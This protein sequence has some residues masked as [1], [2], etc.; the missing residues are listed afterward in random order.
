MGTT[1]GVY[2]FGGACRAAAAAACSTFALLCIAFLLVACG[3]SRATDDANAH[4][5]DAP[6]LPYHLELPVRPAALP[7]IVLPSGSDLNTS[8]LIVRDALIEAGHAPFIPPVGDATLS[9]RDFS[10]YL[11]FQQSSLGPHVHH[12]VFVTP[13]VWTIDR[14]DR[15][16]QTYYPMPAA[17]PIEAGVPYFHFVTT[18]PLPFALE[19]LFGNAWWGALESALLYDFARIDADGGGD[20][21]RYASATRS[22]LAEF[23][24]PIDADTSSVAVLDAVLAQL[25]RS[26]GPSTYR[27]IATLVGLG[28]LLGETVAARDPRIVWTSA[29]DAMATLYGMRV[30]GFTDAYLRPIDYVLQVYHVPAE[31]PL[32][33][34]AEIVEAR[35]RQ[36]RA[37]GDL[38][39][40]QGSRD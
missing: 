25:P 2:E 11:T 33:A 8:F 9:A 36:I 37:D 26:T 31:R 19:Y 32:R 15:F 6:R 23:G 20:R 5:F 27:P 39:T 17:T 28:I 16:V 7:W 14:I 34:Y 30:E 21:V 24:V 1:R 10:Q 22:R 13:Y 35:V 40:Q 38:S 29:E 18:E 3:G 12:V 4:A